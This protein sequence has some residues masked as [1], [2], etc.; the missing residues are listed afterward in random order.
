MLRSANNIHLSIWIFDS[1]LHLLMKQCLWAFYARRLLVMIPWNPKMKNKI[2]I[3]FKM[4]KEKF[5]NQPNVREIIKA[6]AIADND[7]LKT[8]YSISLNITNKGKLYPIWEYIKHPT[9]PVCCLFR[10]FVWSSSGVNPV[11]NSHTRPCGHFTSCTKN[12]NKYQTTN[13]GWKEKKRNMD[14]ELQNT[15]R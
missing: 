2:L 11:V 13:R 5:R 8:S 7:G 15:G 12:K 10:S 4:L 3:F 14:S 9:R 6:S 1:Y